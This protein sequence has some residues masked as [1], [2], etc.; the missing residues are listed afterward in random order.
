M[1]GK[2]GAAAPKKHVDKYANKPRLETPRQ[3]QQP[4]EHA[5][6]KPLDQSTSCANCGMS[7]SDALLQPWCSWHQGLHHEFVTETADERAARITAETERA[8]VL[9][10]FHNATGKTLK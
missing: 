6:T 2:K 3:P 7:Q 9:A 10:D 5:T 8:S 4:K 1:S